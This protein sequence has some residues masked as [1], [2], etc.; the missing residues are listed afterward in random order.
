MGETD[1]K[2]EISLGSVTNSCF[3]L[4]PFSPSYD[5]EYKGVIQPAVEAA[6]LECIRGDEI[7]SKPQI[8]AD[9]W[10]SLRAARVVVAELTGRNS[11]VF[12]ELGLAHAIGKPVVIITKSEDDVPFDLKGL[13]YVYYNVDDPFWGETLRATITSMLQ[14]VLEEEQF[15]TVFEDITPIGEIH[16]PAKKPIPAVKRA[17]S[18]PV[19]DVTGIWQGEMEIEEEEFSYNLNLHL[20]QQDTKLSGTMVVSYTFKERLTV[21]QQ[22]MV[23]EIEADIVIVRGVSYSFLQQ[24]KS[25]FYVLDSFITKLSTDGT[26]LSGTVTSGENR[27][28]VV[29][30]KIALSE[31][32]TLNTNL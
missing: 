1:N 18:E 5:A 16:Y 12:Y 26:E 22:I 27:G 11:N 14:K 9:I 7:Y 29:L 17:I 15:G 25:P 32:K 21:V 2:V 6:G 13:R 8:T 31:N 4:M 30:R 10:K 28:T 19:R 24:G 3:V 20:I 23:G